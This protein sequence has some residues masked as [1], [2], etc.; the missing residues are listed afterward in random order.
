LK[1][2]ERKSKRKHHKRKTSRL[3]PGGTGALISLF[4]HQFISCK[5]RK[6]WAVLREGIGWL[7]ILNIALLHNKGYF[8][9]VLLLIFG[10]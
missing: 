5:G 6:I 4:K 7:A 9:H 10:L 3:L 1:E 8:V 2:K